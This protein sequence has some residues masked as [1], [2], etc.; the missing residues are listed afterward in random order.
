MPPR[1]KLRFLAAEDNLVNQR[2]IARLLESA[3]HSV[4]VVGDGLAAVNASQQNRYD[5]ILMDVQ[6]PIM[7]GHEATRQIRHL[8]Q[9]TGAHVPIIAMTAHAM[10]GDREK[11][12]EAGMDD[13]I[14]KPLHKQELLQAIYEQT[15]RKPLPRRKAARAG[16]RSDFC[17][18]ANSTS[19]A[20]CARWAGTKICSANFAA[21]FSR[22]VRL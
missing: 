19:K 20:P 18:A 5:A 9:T 21:S 16:F 6:M 3:G 17:R 14:A 4:T 15:A 12:L 1:R 7:D 2:L 22:R 8:E 13:Y 10:K 11:C